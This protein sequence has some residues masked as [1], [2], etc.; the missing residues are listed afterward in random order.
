MFTKRA[1]RGAMRK[2]NFKILAL[3]SSLVAKLQHR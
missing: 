3:V 1:N 2:P